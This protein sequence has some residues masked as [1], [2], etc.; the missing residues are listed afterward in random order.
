MKTLLSRGAHFL[1]A[2]TLAGSLLCANPLF[3]RAEGGGTG[4][5]TLPPPVFTIQSVTCTTGSGTAPAPAVC[6]VTNDFILYEDGAV[7][8]PDG[9]LFLPE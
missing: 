5:K 4:G 3:V 9:S 6:V 8:F 7:L 2:A 1:T